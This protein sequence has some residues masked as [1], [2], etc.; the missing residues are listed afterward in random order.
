FLDGVLVL[1]RYCQLVDHLRSVRADDVGTED[2]AVFRVADDLDE[3]LGFSRRAG[4]SVGGERKFADLVV[5]LLFLD[6]RLGKADRSDFWMAVGR[7]RYVAVIHLV[8]VLL[9]GEKLGEHDAFA[10]SLMGQHWRAGNVPNGVDPLDRSL[11]PLVDLDEAAI[12]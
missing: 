1:A 9:A 11:H 8:H 3:A 12:G 7:V 5:D 6:L 10:L 4:A 2:L